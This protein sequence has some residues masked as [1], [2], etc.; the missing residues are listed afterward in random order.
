LSFVFAFA[1]AAIVLVGA[2]YFAHRLRR[3]RAETRPFAPAHLVSP[4]PPRA[5]RR[6]ELED[7]ALFGT[8]ALAVLAL[9]LLGASP[10]VHCTRLSLSRSSGASVA[11]AVVLDD[12]MSM[13]ANVGARSRWDR[14]KDGA[15]EL[16]ASTREGDAVAIVLAGAPARVALAP[17]TDL[18]GARAMLD[19]LR[20]SDRGTDLDGAL[21]MARDL[22]LGLPQVDRRVVLLSDLADGLPNAPPLGEGSA[23][24]M[25]NAL[26]EIVADGHDCAIVRADR[27][28]VRVRVRVACSPG[29]DVTKAPARTVTV[30]FGDKAL[31]EGSAPATEAGDVILTLPRDASQK[32]D[33][34]GALVA[35]LG[36]TDAVSADDEAPVVAEAVPGSV[37]V[38][39]ATDA[40]TAATGG[41]PVVEQALSA[42][43]L[44]VA[45]RPLPQI[46]DRADDLSAFVGV[47]LDDPP[48]FTP[49]E[50]RALGGFVER[51]GVLLLALGPHAASPP[52]GASLEPFLSQPVAWASTTSP[53]VDPATAVGSLSESAASLVD[54]AA[55]HR[56]ELRP[57]DA[58]AFAP[59]LQWKDHAPL[60]LRRTMGR[61]EVWVVTLPFAL[62]ASELP[63]RPSFLALLAG[64]VDAARARTVPKRTEVGTAWSF[65]GAHKVTVKGPG[66]EELPVL[67]DGP[68]PRVVPS[69][70]GFYRIQVDG[71]SEARVAE[72]VPRELDLR[73]RKLSV[74]A[75][76]KAFGENRSAID[77]SPALAVAL[78][79]LLVLELALRV[80]AGRKTDG[81]L[82]VGALPLG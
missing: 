21:A 27:A 74:T 33:E 70:L 14:A 46:P 63:L 59:L 3:R 66:G 18:R 12:S 29:F 45:V 7:R 35:R 19:S 2:P 11:L 28:G 23:V 81:P 24:P 69:R 47:L 49:E 32:M 76:G 48:G 40:E 17:T 5:R 72:L 71:R 54:L 51:G 50:R 15:A 41:A 56:V 55:R 13:Q 10:F 79:V 82:P 43:A 31:A 36:G 44:D 34:P 9:A 58:S 64:W 62:D 52:L 53:G 68:T 57:E 6:S 61:G 38:V 75:T 77:A 1:L 8:R 26:P 73:P 4:A 37:A 20:G 78:L 16:L 67:E 25:W 60:V 65:A 30:F 80:R 42:L 22:V 39:V